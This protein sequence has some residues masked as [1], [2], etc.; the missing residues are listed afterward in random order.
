MHRFDSLSDVCGYIHDKMQFLSIKEIRKIPIAELAEFYIAAQK[1]IEQQTVDFAKQIG[2]IKSSDE[3]GVL[4]YVEY[5]I[6]NH[7]CCYYD[8][9]Y[10]KIYI[11]LIT[12]VYGSYEYVLS[13]I[14]HELCHLKIR[15]HSKC[16]YELHFNLLQRLGI[17]PEQLEFND[18]YQLNSGVNAKKYLY[19]YTD[20]IFKSPYSYIPLKLKSGESIIWHTESENKRHDFETRRNIVTKYE[21]LRKS[22][23]FDLRNPSKNM[24]WISSENLKI[25]EKIA[26]EYGVSLDTLPINFSDKMLNNIL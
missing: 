1:Y 20:D 21:E 19:K 3:L 14:V 24:R 22:R 10:P 8:L 7:G 6:K 25:V 4:F 15:G 2:F 13:V 5:M 17:I 26:F 11:P 16:F 23:L 9:T 18:V 12:L